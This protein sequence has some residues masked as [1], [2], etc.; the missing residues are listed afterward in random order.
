MSGKISITE[1]KINTY[2]E[3]RPA[4]IGK[5]P[6]LAPSSSLYFSRDGSITA[7]CYNRKF[8]LGQ[9]PDDLPSKVWNSERR[10]ELLKA[11]NT[12]KLVKGCEG[13]AEL[14]EAG[15]VENVLA[16]NFD[17]YAEFPFWS[18]PGRLLKAFTKGIPPFWNQ[19]KAEGRRVKYGPGLHFRVSEK[20]KLLEFELSNIC[21]LECAMCFG[22][23]SSSIRKNRDHLPPLPEVYDS[24]FIE[25]LDHFLPHIWEAKFYGGEPFLIPIYFE[26]WDRIR[27][28]NP[29]A[30]IHITTNGTILNH[31]VRKV[32]EQLNVHL[33]LSID[34]FQIATYEPLRKNA[35][36]ERVSAHID[37]F[38][39]VIKSK[40]R[41]MVIS[42]CP[43][44]INAHE[45]PE[46]VNQCN[47]RD[48]HLH[49]NTVWW[50]EE[51]SRRKAPKEWLSSLVEQYQD[52]F[53]A[54][55]NSY[56]AINRNK[57]SG[58][59]NQSTSWRDAQNE[60]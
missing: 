21:N 52:A 57:F 50:P 60:I 28:H 29:N 49:F 43:T 17:R 11:F 34:S 23:F 8:K 51:L 16:K 56:S 35:N 5:A 24:G 47:Q 38:D 3:S 19:L 41:T 2:Q 1:S 12:G 58:L 25:D 27:K 13:C 36:F 54:G 39:Q 48:W 6:C 15:N 55:K 59:I 10:L 26:I 33:I 22:D 44:I 37:Y 40:K 31:K 14:I 53:E 9:Y 20:P 42:I 32:L 46:I 45:I 4:G 7:C 30:R 18:L